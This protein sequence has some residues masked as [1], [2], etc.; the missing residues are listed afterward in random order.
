LGLFI[1]A[2]DRLQG[3]TRMI[4]VPIYATRALGL[5]LAVLLGFIGHDYLQAEQSFRTLRMESAKIGVSGLQ[6]PPPHLLLL[7]QLEAYQTFVHTEARAGMSPKEVET[8]RR[9]AERYPT[10]PALFRYALIAGLN[11]QADTAA[12]TLKRLCRIHTKPRCQEGRDGWI[13]L[14]KK[15]PQLLAISAPEFP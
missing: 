8:M 13:A 2:V 3:H 10:P 12:L 11:G 6:T 7:N 9:T 4:T 14:Q 5:T 1:G 15:H